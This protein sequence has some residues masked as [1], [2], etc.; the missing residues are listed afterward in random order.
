MRFAD[1]LLMF[2]E[3]ENEINGGPTSAAK[4]ALKR[5]RA[6]AFRGLDPAVIAEKV[7]RY[8]DNLS[9]KSDFFNAL[10][11]ERAWELG[12]E[13]L[14]KHDLVRWNLMGPKFRQMR[15]DLIQMGMDAQSWDV[16]SGIASSGKYSHLPDKLYWKR[17]S[18][19]IKADFLNINEHVDPNDPRLVGYTTINWLTNLYPK[20]SNTGEYA[21]AAFITQSWRGCVGDD[22]T[23]TDP[24][25]YILPI[26]QATIDAA[27]GV[28]QNY[29]GKGQ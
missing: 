1:V 15:L 18:D 12:G 6:R 16:S 14:R 19:G 4:E 2:A 20:N 22:V 10:V 8:V 13:M 5:V 7:D 21:P 11:D 26:P 9:S 28:L 29:Y 25:P 27:G 24:V 23:S 3:T 17:G